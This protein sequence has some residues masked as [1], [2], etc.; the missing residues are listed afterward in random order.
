MTSPTTFVALVLLILNHS[1]GQVLPLRTYT[2]E[3]GFIADAVTA[4]YQDS[5]GYLWICTGD[6]INVFDGTAVR[7]LTVA[8]GLALN[9]TT[10]IAESRR[11]PGRM[12]IGTWGGGVS[13]WNG[14]MF[15]TLMPDSS[16]AANTILD[17]AEDGEGTLWCVT[18]DGV[19]RL[20]NERFAPVE[21]TKGARTLII[22]PD[23]L[24]LIG[25]PREIFVFTSG[26]GKVEKRIPFSASGLPTT[27]HHDREGNLWLATTD[28][29]LIRFRNFSEV[30]RYPI[31]DGTVHTIAGDAEGTLWLGTEAGLLKFSPNAPLPIFTRYT[32]ENGLRS[33]RISACF[34]DHEGTLWVGSADATGLQQLA[35]HHVF[36]F[37]VGETPISYNNTKAV[38]DRRGHIWSITGEGLWETWRDP[39]GAWQHHLHRRP[40]VVNESVPTIVRDHRERLWIDTGRRIEC[41][42][43]DSTAHGPSR[44]YAVRTLRP[45]ADIPQGLR[46]F[47]V[48]DS[49]DNLWISMLGRGVYRLSLSR[50]DERVWH[51]SSRNGLPSDDVRVLFED[52]EH[53]MWVGSVAEGVVLVSIETGSILRTYSTAD[54]LPED[55][56][57]AIVQDPSGAIW[58]GTRR[59]GVTLYDGSTFRMIS[60]E[61]GLPSAAVWALAVDSANGLVWAGTSQGVHRLDMKSGRPLEP[62]DVLLGKPVTSLGVHAGRSL[63]YVT[64]DALTVYEVSA[65]VKPSPSPRMHIRGL[66]VNGLRQPLLHN[67]RFSHDQNLF[68][69][70]YLGVTFREPGAIRYQYK[71]EALEDEWQ[72]PTTER[73]ITYASLPPGSYVFHVRATTADGAVLG[74]PASLAFTIVPP[75]WTRWWFLLLAALTVLGTIMLVIH[76]RERRLLA[77][78]HLRARIARDLH[79]EIGSNLSSIAMASDLLKRQHALEEKDRDKLSE[80]ARVASSTVREMKDIVWLIRPGNDSL[81]DLFLRMKDTAALLLDGHQYRLDFP[82]E[83]LGRNVA[84]EWRQHVYLIYKE[85]VANAARH[86][87]AAQVS[88][89]VRVDSDLL[90][91]IVEDDGKGFAMD[92]VNSGHGLHNMRERANLL[93][94]RLTID[95][96]LEQGTRVTFQTRIT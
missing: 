95:S 52:N 88:V 64:K 50:S 59:K 1:F 14:E 28:R 87:G 47:F 72:P 63:W 6:G 76:Q 34:V 92:E 33:N 8:D 13:M 11:A 38:T 60:V 70:E 67:L 23:S 94:A 32:I 62:L 53:R 55:L 65:A 44:L 40:I 29:L 83:K 10:C 46:F 12:F 85:A 84:L 77:I 78:E 66:S 93:K 25:T 48:I 30:A 17:V 86:S 5:R 22:T 36:T 16:L 91:L 51:F 90:T 21:G 58:I 69:F 56:I 80:I 4:L 96:A 20:M 75:F 3:Q 26:S 81:D 89:R 79:D 37:P 74:S 7:T 43:M 68:T 15:T 19:F 45:G 61:H 73:S 71:M 49:R 9:H 27:M 82:V 35:D 42:D 39:E 54:G 24:V 2:P 31:R 41:Y 57:R 18:A